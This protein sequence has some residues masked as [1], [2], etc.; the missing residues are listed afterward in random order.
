[1]SPTQ[2]V[3]Q[4][5]ARSAEENPAAAGQE[6]PTFLMLSA[7]QAL[8]HVTTIPIRLWDRDSIIPAHWIKGLMVVPEHRNGLYMIS[9]LKFMI[10]TNRLQTYRTIIQ[11]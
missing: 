5:R 11:F 6:P 1:M 9:D 10:F 3:R 7:D 4:A 8:G 2:R